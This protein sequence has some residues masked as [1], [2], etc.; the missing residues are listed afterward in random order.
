MKSF[1]YKDTQHLNYSEQFKYNIFVVKFLLSLISIDLINRMLEIAFSFKR[2]TSM[3]Y[4]KTDVSLIHNRRQFPLSKEN[5]YCEYH[6]IVP[7][8]E[9]GEPTAS[10]AGN[11]CEGTNLICLTAR[12]HYI[13]HLLLYK[14][15]NDYKML[16]AIMSFRTYSKTLRNTMK[17]NSKLYEKLKIYWAKEL[18]KSNSGEGNPMYGKKLKDCMTPEKYAEWCKKNGDCYWANN[19]I[20]QRKIKNNQPLPEGFV[21]GRLKSTKDKISKANSGRQVSKEATQKMI[22]TKMKNGTRKRTRE[23]VEKQMR[24]RI[25][26]GISSATTTGFKWFTDGVHQK[27]VDPANAPEGWHEGRATQRFKW[28]TDGIESKQFASGS[29]IPEGWMLGRTIATKNKDAIA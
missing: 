22:E 10:I 21:K 3:N 1:N 8:S 16:N 4:Q 25:E 18:S 6:H 17:I 26:R 19:G 28:Y 5:G 24:T 7:I 27:L 2:E 11:N 9:G 29:K 14:I 15:Y 20:I 13:A 12:E 23:S